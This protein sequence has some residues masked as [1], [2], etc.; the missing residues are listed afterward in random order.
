MY[1]ENM[2]IEITLKCPACSVINIKK[3]GKKRNKEQNYYWK[4]CI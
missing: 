2:T 3:N 4:D 1:I